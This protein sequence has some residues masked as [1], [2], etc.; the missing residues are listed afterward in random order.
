MLELVAAVT[1]A[2]F[3]ALAP[4]LREIVKLWVDKSPSTFQSRAGQ[5]ILEF[6]GIK[7]KKP[8]ETSD[9]L[10]KLS[11]TSTQ[12]DTIL[13]EIGRLAQERQSKMLKLEND[14][15]LLSQREQ[16]IK[17]RIEGL[18][19]VPLPAAEYF[20]KLVE[21]TE[22][23]SQ[24]RDYVLFLGGVIVTAVVAVVLKKLGWG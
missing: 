15:T 6:L 3:G 11:R 19:K 14:L 10:S 2:L 4:A 22:K 17:A 7:P 21:K 12:M 16:E 20:A 23:K 5:S 24:V 9:L 1:A 8:N 18:E 13:A